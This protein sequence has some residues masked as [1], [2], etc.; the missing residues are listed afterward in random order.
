MLLNCVPVD[1]IPKDEWMKLS[2]A[3]RSSVDI[4]K[5]NEAAAKEPVEALGLLLTSS[6][7]FATAISPN[8]EPK[9]LA[10]DLDSSL[11]S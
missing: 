4:H 2:T 9:L 11:M 5:L 1:E 6:E 10:P 7:V 8:G 3:L